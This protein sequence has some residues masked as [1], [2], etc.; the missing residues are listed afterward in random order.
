M[1]ILNS[2]SPNLFTP[3]SALTAISP[4]VPYIGVT[5]AK[6]VSIFA[7]IFHC[8]FLVCFMG[9]GL[10]MIG[11]HAKSLPA[12]VV[13]FKP[14]RDLAD[15]GVIRK[16]MSTNIS[17]LAVY[18]SEMKQSIAM[19][20]LACFPQPALIRRLFIYLHPKSF[21]STTLFIHTLIIPRNRGV[22]Q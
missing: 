16:F 8:S 17:S 2:P 20:I 6:G 11:I 5:K 14:V 7:A 15:S 21:F 10:K 4:T 3:R 9:N 12:Q 13:E 18:Y 19:S 22:C 1:S